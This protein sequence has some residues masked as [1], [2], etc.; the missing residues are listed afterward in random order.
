MNH[1]NVNVL[2]KKCREHMSGAQLIRPS[3]IDR[4]L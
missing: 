3:D 4:Y 2:Y 1:V